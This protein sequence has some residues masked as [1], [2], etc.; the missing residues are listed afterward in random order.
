MKNARRLS[1]MTQDDL[2]R[3][4]N[5]WL[6]ST[7]E[8]RMAKLSSPPELSRGGGIPKTSRNP[9][10]EQM[11]L[12]ID[13]L[14][15]TA[16]ISLVYGI[17]DRQSLWLIHQQCL[18]VIQARNQTPTESGRNSVLEALRQADPQTPITPTT[19]ISQ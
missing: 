7:S 5:E 18:R 2:E 13:A 6:G 12:E 4:L 9:H 15:L 11:S 14:R 3:R 1:S 10:K 8:E 19:G 16:D 17:N